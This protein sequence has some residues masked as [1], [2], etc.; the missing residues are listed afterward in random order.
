VKRLPVDFEPIHIRQHLYRAILAGLGVVYA[1][2]GYSPG[3]I[4]SVEVRGNGDGAPYSVALDAAGATYVAETVSSTAAACQVSVTKLDPAGQVV[5]NFVFG[6]TRCDRPNAIAVDS[7]GSAYIA[8]QT[9]SP[10][11]PMVNAFQSSCPSVVGS[12]GFVAKLSPDGTTLLYSTFLEGVVTAIAVDSSG[13]ATVAGSPESGFTVTPGA[14]QPLPGDIGGSAFVA[15]L[16]PGGGAL[17]MATYFGGEQGYCMGDGVS[18]LRNPLASPEFAP[19][20]SISAIALDEQS[21]VYI[22]GKTD[23]NGFPATTGPVHSPTGGF[24]DFHGGF[25]AK[26]NSTGTAILY[27]R[28]VGDT[29]NAIAVDAEGDAWIG[30][31]TTGVDFAATPGALQAE[32]VGGT[33][34]GFLMKVDPAAQPLYATYIGTSGSD[35]ITNLSLDADGAVYVAGTGAGIPFPNTIGFRRGG[36]FLAQIDPSGSSVLQSVMA[37]AG[38]GAQS[39]ALCGIGDITVAG[40][41]GLVSRLRLS[42]LTDGSIVAV[43][44][45]AASIPT[46]R[47]APGEWIAVYGQGIGPDSAGTSGLQVLFDGA[48]APVFSAQSDQVNAAVPFE[49]A[50]QQ[51]TH[52]QIEWNGQTTYETD[53][54]VY[55]AQP[56]IFGSA[57]AAAG[58]WALDQNGALNCCGPG[59]RSPVQTSIVTILVIGAGLFNVPFNVPFADGFV[60]PASASSV[61]PVLPVSIGMGGSA[62]QVLSL[63]AVPGEAAGPIQIRVRV[64]PAF[65][66]GPVSVT[67]GAWTSRSALWFIQ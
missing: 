53:L 63:G 21:N 2:W 6:G 57:S 17:E 8:G 18:C 15:R 31:T 52:L 12:C 23:S 45:A 62:A 44:N 42:D 5:Y 24:F 59:F 4:F 37:P 22:A 61:E 64:P 60:I 40:S 65:G 10:D 55:P 47:V 58:V 14:V 56:E 49:I 46:L 34:N 25:V 7:S 67:V 30:G 1:A 3:V 13:R 33:Q 51:T 41:S 66:T 9:S 29:V 26:L 20:N 36:E 16:A 39:L 32:L 35:A 27:A 54:S 43:T 50:G 11:F 28:L 19:S 38:F 48:S